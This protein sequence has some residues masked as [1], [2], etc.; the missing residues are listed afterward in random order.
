MNRE[1]IISVAGLNISGIVA[2]VCRAVYDSRGNFE[3]SSMTLL[4]NHFSLMVLVTLT[5]PDSY[6]DLTAACNRLEEEAGL[7]INIFPNDDKNSGFWPDAS[8]PNYEIRAKGRDRMGIMYRAAHLLASMGINIVE[9]ETKVVEA[10]DGTP[11]FSLR[12]AVVVP[13]NIDNETLRKNLKV[14][15]ENNFETISLIPV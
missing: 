9:M 7:K 4:E 13:E 5:D 6:D 10:K 1:V 2:K 14:L 8:S 15:A 3:H 12:T 11:L